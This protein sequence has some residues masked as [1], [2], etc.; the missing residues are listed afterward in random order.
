MKFKTLTCSLIA[1]SIFGSSAVY[2][3]PTRHSGGDR[4]RPSVQQSYQ[5][6]GQRPV[7]QQQAQRPEN[8]KPQAYQHNSRPQAQRPNVQHHAKAPGHNR[9]NTN[10]HRPNNRPDAYRPSHSARPIAH[11]KRGDRA[12]HHFRGHRYHVYNWNAHGLTPPPHGHHWA[13]IG[14]DFVLIAVATG[15]ITT[16]ILN[17]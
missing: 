11:F 9:P 8:R 6:P 5:K 2:A 3:Q 1:L 17:H 15:V 14:N 10:A 7:N 13:K 4:N 12:P 16:I